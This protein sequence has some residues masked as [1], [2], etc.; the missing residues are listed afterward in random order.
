MQPRFSTCQACG[1]ERRSDEYHDCP[2]SPE[3]LTPEQAQAARDVQVLREAARLLALAARD[4]RE[5]VASIPSLAR[6]LARSERYGRAA[7]ACGELADE[8]S[9]PADPGG[10]RDPRHSNP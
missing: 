5:A 7:A 6:P 8:K 3:H 1:C 4:E 10:N 2:A 9:S